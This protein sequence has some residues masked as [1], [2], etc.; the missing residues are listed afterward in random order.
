MKSKLSVICTPIGNLQDLSNRAIDVLKKSEIIF[1][2]SQKL[3]KILIKEAIIETTKT[4]ISCSCSKEKQNVNLLLQALSSKM[5]TCLISD[6]G[7]PTINDPGSILIKETL[8]AGHLVEVIPGPNAIIT[9]IIGSGLTISR[10]SFL[11]FLPKKG[12]YRTQLILHSYKLGL[13]LII[14]ESPKRIFNTLK[15]LYIL[16]GPRKIVIARELTKYFET[17]HRGIL[18]SVFSPPLLSKGELTI[19]VE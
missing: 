12:L 7:A 1:S 9:S 19:I 10:F 2:E 14:F 4:I 6:A 16:L 5:Q 8:K 18:G 13:S 11:G 15:E 3:V 17:Y